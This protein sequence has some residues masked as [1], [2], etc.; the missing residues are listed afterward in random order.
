[1]ML[2]LHER[3]TADFTKGR[4]ADL[5]AAAEVTLERSVNDIYSVYFKYPA[6]DEKA[7]LIKEN[8]IVSL[9]GQGYVILKKSRV[10]DGTD[11]YEFTAADIFSTLGRAKHIQNIPDRIGEKPSEIFRDVLKDSAF[12][13]F[14]EAELAALDMTWFDSDGVRVDF[15][16]VDKTNI[17]DTALTLI[18]NAGRGEIYRDNYKVAIV[19]RI[20][21]DNGVRLTLD[22][23]ME[24][25]T[26]TTDMDGI[27]TRLYPYGADDLHIGSVEKSAVPTS[28][29]GTRILK[30]PKAKDIQYI[31]SPNADKYGTYDGYRDYSDYTDPEKVYMNAVWEFSPDNEDRIDVPKISVSGKLIDLARLADYGDIEKINIGDTV[32]VYDNDGAV[33][34]ERVIKLT[35]YPF[36]PKET[37]VEIGH[38]EVNPFSFIWQMYQKTHRYD[39][40]QTTSGGIASR[41]LSGTINSSRNNVRSQNELLKIVGDLLTIEDG[42]RIRIRLG[43]YDG[44]FV[45]MIYDKRG[46]RAIYLNDAGEAVFTGS[47]ET[48]KDA[49]IGRNL[50]LSV[51]TDD[52]IGSAIQFLTDSGELVGDM[53]CTDGGLVNIDSYMKNGEYG[54]VYINAKRVITSEDLSPVLSDIADLKR[55]VSALEESAEGGGTG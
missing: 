1:M 41:K 52:E 34:A 25:L 9:D 49:T 45:F 48:D 35:E 44:E 12:T 40:S 18:E 8:M 10:T 29:D 6:S 46:N 20:G 31:E 32:H 38:I 23:N 42:S 28:S 4:T 3:G 16:M 51:R 54:F 13:A 33:Y 47:I 11:M 2:R 30:N 24:N 55:R 26:V 7:A 37:T 17:W 39:R 21:K 19:K 50:K 36:E 14:T 15:F 22:K 53:R 43:N 5:D 27:I